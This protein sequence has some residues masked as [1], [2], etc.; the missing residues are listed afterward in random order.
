[1]AAR[2]VADVCA[3]IRSII[4]KSS[5]RMETLVMLLLLLRADSNSRMTHNCHLERERE[6]LHSRKDSRFQ[7]EMTI[8]WHLFP[9]ACDRCSLYGAAHLVDDFVSYYPVSH[10]RAR[11]HVR[12]DEP[13]RS[14]VR[15]FRVLVSSSIP[16]TS[17]RNTGSLRGIRE[18]GRG[19]LCESD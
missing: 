13:G 3:A 14:C 6:I 5:F 16:I 9:A 19:T 1:V 8:L 2:V 12:P 7:L 17:K 4:A 11:R 10:Y 15:R 18:A